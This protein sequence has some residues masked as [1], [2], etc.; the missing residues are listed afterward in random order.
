[1]A[2]GLTAC[3]FCVELATANQKANKCSVV[4]GEQMFGWCA[5]FAEQMFEKYFF[6]CMLVVGVG[7]RLTTLTH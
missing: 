4:L 3:F 5:L 6:I 1:V 7:G 2:S